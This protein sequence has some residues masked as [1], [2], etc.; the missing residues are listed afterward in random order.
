[1]IDSFD[2]FN[3]LE[4]SAHF[5]NVA[6]G[7]KGAIILAERSNRLGLSLANAQEVPIKLIV[8][9]PNIVRSTTQYKNPPTYFLPIHYQILDNIKKI[10]PG[11]E[12]NNAMIEIYD[13]SYKSMGYHSDL[14][15]DL[16]D[17]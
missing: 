15:L 10:F 17:D 4:K 11:F 16:A 3:I 7:R 13:N 9:S 5:E 1:N 12:A 14:A 2:F 8:S 6:K